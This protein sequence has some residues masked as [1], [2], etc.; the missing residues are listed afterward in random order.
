MTLQ[1]DD[2]TEIFSFTQKVIDACGPRLAGDPS[3]R[4]AAEM[5][6][7]EF[8]T[9]CDSVALE[10]FEVHPNAF[11]GQLR[12]LAVIYPLV[13][14]CL[15]FQWPLVAALGLSFG[16]LALV[17]EAILYREYLDRFWKKKQGTNVI[18]IIEPTAEVKQQVIVSAHHDSAYIF[19]FLS[20]KPILYPILSFGALSS[21]IYVLFMGWLWVFLGVNASSGFQL[22]LQISATLI[23]PLVVVLWF[24]RASTGTPG[25]GDNMVSVA[26]ANQLGKKFAKEKLLH[27]RLILAS[28]D[29]EEAGLRGARAYCKKHKADLLAIP[30]FNFNMDSPYALK[31]LSFLTTDVNGTVRLSEEMASECVVIAQSLGYDAKAFPI[32]FLI[33]GTD[34]GEFGR[35]GVTATN[36]SAMSIETI[37]HVGTYH[38]PNDTID[39]IEPAAVEAAF[40][41]A[42]MFVQQKDQQI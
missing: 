21:I 38:T 5:I 16:F 3:T 12:L 24:F 31:N 20:Y 32:P 35:I 17:S 42:T 13:V 33:G 39:A 29:A 23:T 41:I 10:S 22:F 14:I 28:F 1:S 25:A 27:T 30:T 19:N 9:H 11:L 40:Q 4:K 18:G 15:W 6:R 26:I 2:V 36:L 37:I 7:D 34:A 8:A